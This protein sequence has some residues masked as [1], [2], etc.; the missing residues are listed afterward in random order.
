MLNELD[1]KVLSTIPICQVEGIDGGIETPLCTE[2]QPPTVEACLPQESAAALRTVESV[3][4]GSTSTTSVASPVIPPSQKIATSTAMSISSAVA[5]SASTVT[6]RS[7]TTSHVQGLVKVE[8]SK[9]E[10]LQQLLSVETQR[11]AVERE[12]LALE[13]DRLALD[14][15]RLELKE[16]MYNS[17]VENFITPVISFD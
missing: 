16:R 3:N 4:A 11:L 2:D 5:T 14:R 7:G 17:N 1:E 13:R 9:L 15:Q 10:V 6:P 8:E 12:R